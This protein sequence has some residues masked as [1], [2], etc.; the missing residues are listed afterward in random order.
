[1]GAGGSGRGCGGEEAGGMWW[2]GLD[3]GERSR[4]GVGEGE[5]G[6]SDVWGGGFESVKL[7]VG[8]GRA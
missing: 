1:M 6:T 4:E 8:G 7:E 2:E 3:S 5:E